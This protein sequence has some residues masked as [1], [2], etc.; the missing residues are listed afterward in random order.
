M[1]MH[2]SDDIEIS[3]LAMAAISMSTNA[4]EAFLL[5]YSRFTKPSTYTNSFRKGNISRKYR[6]LMK[7]ELKVDFPEVNELIRHRH[8]IV[9]HEPHS[10]RVLTLG[11]VTT[12]DDA[13]EAAETTERFFSDI[14]S[15]PK[16]K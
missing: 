1:A 9:H 16:L 3:C 10:Q 11:N 4:I 2:S 5:E 12:S 8:D 6:K 15:C 14:I 7:S 13:I